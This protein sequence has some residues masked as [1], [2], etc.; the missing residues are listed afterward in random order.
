[1]QLLSFFSNVFIFSEKKRN[2]LHMPFKTNPDLWTFVTR[3]LPLNR[4]GGGGGVGWVLSDE[5]NMSTAEFT[6]HFQCFS[7]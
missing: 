5:A 3:M 2:L 6:E 7:H 1:M 4:G